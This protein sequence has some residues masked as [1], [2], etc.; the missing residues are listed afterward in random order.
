MPSDVVLPLFTA[1]L[2]DAGINARAQRQ[3]LE[4]CDAGLAA[5]LAADAQQLPV[6]ALVMRWRQ[7]PELGSLVPME[8]PAR[9]P[10]I[11]AP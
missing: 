11:E 5:Q 3:I 1:A 6:G 8:H 4:A 2:R 10:A 7:W 9:E